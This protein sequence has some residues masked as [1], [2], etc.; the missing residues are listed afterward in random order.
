MRVAESQSLSAIN[1]KLWSNGWPTDPK[2][3]AELSES[4]KEQ[5]RAYLTAHLHRMTDLIHQYEEG[6][7]TEQ[8]YE[9]G[10]R[11]TIVMWMTMWKAAEIRIH[12]SDSVERVYRDAIHNEPSRSEVN[13]AGP[14]DRD[15]H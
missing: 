4:E 3:F 15:D 12:L 10:I 6:L 13:V 11:G 8:Y 5:C 7:L 9:Q 1:A 14:R 2:A